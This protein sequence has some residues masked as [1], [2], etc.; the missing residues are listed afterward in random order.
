MYYFFQNHLVS[1]KQDFWQPKSNS[2]ISL[3]CIFATLVLQSGLR[4]KIGHVSFNLFIYHSTIQTMSGCLAKSDL[5]L[6]SCEYSGYAAREHFYTTLVPAHGFPPLHHQTEESDQLL[7]TIKVN[8]GSEINI[9]GA[10]AEVRLNLQ[11]SN[12]FPTFIQVTHP[13]H[14]C[15]HSEG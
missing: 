5:D 15:S 7:V 2:E 9:A 6:A 12:L 10:A 11:F 4:I 14:P 8:T 3:L 1:H 13:P